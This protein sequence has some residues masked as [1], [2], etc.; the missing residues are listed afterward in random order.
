MSSAKAQAFLPEKGSDASLTEQKEAAERLGMVFKD[1][2]SSWVDIEFSWLDRLRLLF[3]GRCHLNVRVHTENVLG[4]YVNAPTY[5]RV[6]QIF[7]KRHGGQEVVTRF[8]G[9]EKP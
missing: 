7:P 3:H 1:S 2:V 6:P 4:A 9:N 5:I 8:G